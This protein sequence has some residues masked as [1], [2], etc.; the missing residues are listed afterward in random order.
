MLLRLSSSF[1]VFCMFAECFY[2]IAKEV[3]C[4]SSL[5]YP[6]LRLYL[7]HCCPTPNINLFGWIFSNNRSKEKTANKQKSPT[8][9]FRGKKGKVILNKNRDLL[10]SKLFI[11]GCPMES[12]DHIVGMDMQASSENWIKRKIAAEKSKSMGRWGEKIP[13]KKTIHR[14]HTG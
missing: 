1:K 9:H 8:V 13:K 14:E 10:E 3:L 6:E 11:H 2:T 4:Y 12:W 7:S 5:L